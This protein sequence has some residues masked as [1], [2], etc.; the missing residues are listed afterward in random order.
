MGV[1]LREFISRTVALFNSRQ[2]DEDLDRELQTHLTLL[3]DDFVRHGMTRGDA[4]YAARRQFGG[5]A[6][7][8]QELHEA[9]SFRLI[10]TLFQDVRH[11]IRGLRRTPGFTLTVLA[12]LMLGIGVNVAIF[13]VANTVLLKPLKAPGAD[14][15]VQIENNFQGLLASRVGLPEFNLWR[16]QVSIFEDVS[17]YRL[18]VV[19]LTG[20]PYPEQIPLARVSVDFLHL[21]GAP[22]LH[23]RTFSGD[24]DRPN[25]GHVTVL[26]YG[27]W[28]RR[29]GGDPQ[30]IGKVITL[31]SDP[32]VVIG[33]LGPG[34]DTEQFDQLPSVWVP[35]QIEPNT[36]DRGSYCSVAG[37]LKPGATLG[38]A[39]A[40]L[41]PVAEEFRRAFPN[42]STKQSFTVQPLRDAMVGSIRNP[43]ILLAGAVS[44]VL[45]I[46]CANVANLLLVRA[47]AR[48]RE[49]AIRAAVGA[50]RGRV[51]RQLLTESILL[52]LGGGALGLLLGLSG[53]RSLLALYPNN[54]VQASFL[55]PVHIP[56]I[57]E[58]GTA[59]TLDWRVLAFTVLV[60]L[61]TGVLFGIFPALRASGADLSTNLKESSGRSGTSFRQDKARSLCVV[62]EMAL[63][64]ILLVGAALFVRTYI[65]LHSVD[66]GFDS[67]GVLTTQM[68]VTGTRF[69]RT[70]D[71]DRLVRQGVDG[72]DALPEVEAVSSACCVPLEAVWQLPFIVDGRPLS[73]QY[74]AFA[75]W[76][77]ISP[78]YFDTF[79]IPILR[80]RAFTERDNSAAP[81]VVIINQALAQRVWPNSDPLKDRLI[82]GRG[83][84]PGYETDTARQVIAIVGDI[85]DSGLNREPRPAVYVPIAQLPDAIN[86]INLRLLPIAWF[87]R[88]R[89][90]SSSLRT[91]ID[92]ELQRA[93]G[94]LPGTRIRS[95][96]EVAAQSTSRKQF[97]MLLMT[98]FGC[99][100]LLLTAIGIYGLM[101]FSVEQRTQEIGIRLALG[102]VPNDVRNMVVV[103]G[104]RLA[105]LGVVIGVAAA[106]GL[107]RVIADFLF[108]VHALDPLV[109]TAAPLFLSGVALLAVWIPAR[110]A[111]RVDPA[112]AL[113]YE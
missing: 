52:S 91:A 24:E 26:S 62:G 19:N 18:E 86:P 21:F 106:L 29:F 28:M 37:R 83:M 112:E 10:E 69:E 102:A 94:G 6:Q 25:G 34:F 47:T 109:F 23:G 4:I 107:T 98:I 111:I 45:L 78:A 84:R 13:S 82:I 92:K 3:A 105:L 108:G 88:T 41:G 65:A 49:I 40:K 90:E 2:L 43:L 48:K 97:E 71:L 50:G 42:F 61:T 77:F 72:I 64:L 39:I 53:I 58:A 75:G 103:E 32:Y 113:R 38:M 9:R 96:S 100:A 15:I 33:I 67:H 11:A 63:A 27:F 31:G 56:G 104:M 110:R 30:T 54:A 7:V 80:G 8:K 81:G 59:V 101:A 57:G 14:R 35:F 5:I 73:G 60:S 70:S 85:R 89:A 95:M 76:T 12:A 46:A 87:I 1:R 16:Q 22:I 79:K 74:H 55:N 99:S 36:Q 44:F 17:A 51:I 20:G 93:S 68:S 66:P